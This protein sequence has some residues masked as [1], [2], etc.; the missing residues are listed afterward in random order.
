MEGKN[1]TLFPGAERGKQGSGLRLI[2]RERLDL[3]ANHFGA[4][5]VAFFIKEIKV[6]L[7]FFNP[8]FRHLLW[9]TAFFAAPCHLGAGNIA[10]LI[11]E[12]KEPFFAFHSGFRHFFCHRIL[13]P[14]MMW[15]ARISPNLSVDQSRSPPT[16]KQ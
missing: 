4:G 1:E 14:C 12:V 9:F 15:M 10:L 11:D 8:H 5:D 6:A 13:T 3:S 7:L 2:V 16:G